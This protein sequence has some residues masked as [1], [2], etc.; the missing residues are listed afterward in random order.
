MAFCNLCG[1][2]LRQWAGHYRDHVNGTVCGQLGLWLY[3]TQKVE[4]MP[5]ITVNPEPG[6]W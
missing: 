3:K 2:S 4:D 1:Q 6:W 5:F